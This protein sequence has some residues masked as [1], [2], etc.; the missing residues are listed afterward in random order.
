VTCISGFPA[1][2]DWQAC[3]TAN[4]QVDVRALD[5]QVLLCE[6]WCAGNAAHV[7]APHDSLR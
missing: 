2:E 1:W 4:V 3:K 6:V 5:G 7:R